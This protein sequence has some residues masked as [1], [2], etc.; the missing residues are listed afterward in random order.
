MLRSRLF[1]F[2]SVP[3]RQGYAHVRNYPSIFQLI[4]QTEAHN[5]ILKVLSMRNYAKGKNIKKEKGENSI[6]LKQTIITST[7]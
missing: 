4:S 2:A 7:L 3:L 5:P 1:C 6:V